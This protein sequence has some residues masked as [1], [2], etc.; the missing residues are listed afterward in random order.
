ML[1]LPTYKLTY[2]TNKIVTT[3]LFLIFTGFFIYN[4]YLFCINSY[5]FIQNYF[6]IN[7]HDVHGEL[8]A[9]IMTGLKMIG[10]YFIEIIILY[11]IKYILFSLPIPKS[12]F[13]EWERTNE[14]STV[15]GRLLIQHFRYNKYINSYELVYL[16]N[17]SAIEYYMLHYHK[18]NP[19]MRDLFIKYDSHHTDSQ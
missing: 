16:L 10:T 15:L 11:T 17:C 4:L 1:S 19:I 5:P 14:I 3:I 8:I 9:L 2:N 13:E 12:W 6:K 18:S 7:S